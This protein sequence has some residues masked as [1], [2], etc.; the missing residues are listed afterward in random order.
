ML[1][2]LKGYKKGV[3]LGGWLSQCEHSKEHHDT[4]ITESDI[5]RISEWGLDHVRVPVD[6]YIF[7]DENGKNLDEGF[8]CIDRCLE[9]C[10]KYH[11]NMILDL[12]KTAGYIFDDQSSIP[13]FSDKSL[14]DKFVE[15]WTEFARRYGKYS[16]RLCFELLNEVV[17]ENLSDAWNEIAARA[18]KAIRAVTKDMRIIIGGA[19]HNSIFCVKNLGKPADENIV[20]TFH[21]YEPLIFTHQGA[22]WVEGMPSDFTLDFPVSYDDAK[23]YTEKYLDAEHCS[24]Y[25]GMEK[26][27]IDKNFFKKF[28]EEAVSVAE[29]YNISLYC[30]EYGVIDRAPTE[31]T[32]KWYEAIHEAFEESGIPRAAWTYKS[33]DFGLVDEHYSAVLERLIKLL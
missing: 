33:K 9:W 17:D 20:Y 6:Y 14:Q 16:E 22:Y 18:V 27:E 8:S 26:A 4:F 31:A 23:K 15:L 3:N 25:Q 1:R 21:C 19:K 7:R 11:L 2:E 32:V 28:F 12:H 30:G 10:E 24:L 13:F 29:K 5:K